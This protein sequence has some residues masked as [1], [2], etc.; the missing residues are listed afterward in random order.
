MLTDSRAAPETIASMYLRSGLPKQGLA[1]SQKVVTLLK[2]HAILQNV[3]LYLAVDSTYI[4]AV[5][6]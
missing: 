3:I 2:T 5:K 6:Q 1:T 4:G